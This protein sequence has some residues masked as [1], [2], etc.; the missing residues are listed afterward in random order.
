VKPRVATVWLGGCSGCHMSL[1]D[2]DERLIDLAG[3]MELVYGPLLD[4]TEFPEGVD[5]TL[6]EGAV[7]NEEKM[8]PRNYPAIDE[9][10]SLRQAVHLM[11]RYKVGRLLVVSRESPGQPPKLISRADILAAFEPTLNSAHER[12]RMIRLKVAR[13]KHQGVV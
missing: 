8:L 4:V 13:R 9:N 5:V 7:A 10:S 11:V 6:V 2:M 12:Q 3:R 1:L